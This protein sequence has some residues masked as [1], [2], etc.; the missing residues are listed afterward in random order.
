M[1]TTVLAFLLTLGVLIV[2]HEYGHYRVAVACGVKVLR[3]SVGFGRVLWRRQ[4]TPE[5]TEFVVCALPFG[6]Y[7]PMLDAREGDVPAAE[8]GRA[9]FDSDEV[10]IKAAGSSAAGLGSGSTSA[11]DSSDDDTGVMASIRHFFADLFGD[12]DNT[13]TYSEA[14]RR[15]RVVVT[16]E[17]DEDR[18]DE[19]RECLTRCGAIDID[20]QVSQWRSEGWTGYDED[21]IGVARQQRVGSEGIESRTSGENRMSGEGRTEGTRGRANGGPRIALWVSQVLGNVRNWR[22]PRDGSVS[23]ARIRWTTQLGERLSPRAPLARAGRPAHGD[24]G[25]SRRSRDPRLSATLKSTISATSTSSA[26]V[27][28]SGSPSATMTGSTPVPS[29]P[30]DSA[31]SCSIQAPRPTS[32]E[33]ESVMTSLLRS[34]EVPPMAEPSCSPGLEASSSASTLMVSSAS[35]SRDSTSAPASPEGTR[36]KAVRAE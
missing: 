17:A 21:G 12:D 20:E 14:V 26:S 6:G 3:F 31:I 22:T 9:G 7:V 33:P 29:L 25:R 35:S 18:L 11:R 4:P 2:I 10:Q 28:S 13:G 24:H 19:A 16:V 34:G 32:G 8:L 1:I 36:P 23:P 30:V 5:S 27:E 15:G